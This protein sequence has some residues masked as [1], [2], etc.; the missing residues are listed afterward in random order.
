MV[1]YLS[2]VSRSTTIVGLSLSIYVAAAALVFLVIIHKLEYFLNARI[3]GSRINAR[4]WELLLAMIVLEAAF[5][6][7]GLI[8]APILRV[9]QERV[10]G[11]AVDL[12]L[13]LCDAAD[14]LS[15]F[16]HMRNLGS[17]ACLGTRQ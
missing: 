15:G 2:A 7:A 1:Q 9:H 14:V 6:I 4:A 8:A 3:V 16:D 12:G 5:G 11:C 17:T 13:S 10:V